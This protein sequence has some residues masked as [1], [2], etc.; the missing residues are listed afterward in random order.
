MKLLIN[1]I[2]TKPGWH[3]WNSN[4]NDNYDEVSLHAIFPWKPGD[5]LLCENSRQGSLVKVQIDKVTFSSFVGQA[6]LRGFA[7]G[8]TCYEVTLRLFDTS[9]TSLAEKIK[10]AK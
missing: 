4:H 2:Q 10:E 3:M 8:E 7:E 1:G 6:A 9:L 5:P